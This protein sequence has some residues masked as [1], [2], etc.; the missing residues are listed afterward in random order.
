[1]AA[2]GDRYRRTVPPEDLPWMY[3]VRG[4]LDEGVAVAAGTDAPYG[5][6]DPWSV[7]R[8]AVERRTAAGA[9]FG[10]HEAVEPEEALGLFTSPLHAPGAARS[11]PEVGDAADLCL[12]TVGWARARRELSAELVAATFV[13]G[14]PVWRKKSC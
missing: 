2:H 4:W 8:A 3:R 13:A 9:P 6:A 12:L 1:V 7:M 10:P 14:R 11:A 5:P